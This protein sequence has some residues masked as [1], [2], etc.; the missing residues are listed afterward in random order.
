MWSA[1][2]REFLQSSLV[3]QYEKPTVG[4]YMTPIL[5]GQ[6]WDMY[7]QKKRGSQNEKKK[8]HLSPRYKK[9]SVLR[10][11]DIHLYKT[12]SGI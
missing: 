11:K 7:F 4:Y 2:V 5:K 1:Q 8:S 9:S 3:Y 10:N 6:K 12:A